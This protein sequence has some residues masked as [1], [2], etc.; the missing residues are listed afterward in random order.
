MAIL[1]ANFCNVPVVTFDVGGNKE[2]I[3]DGKNGYIVPYMEIEQMI[4]RTCELLDKNTR[5]KTHAF[6]NEKFSAK[7]L[8]EKYIAFFSTAV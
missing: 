3:E 5:L 7:A 2:I 4:L 1:E 6:V 8:E